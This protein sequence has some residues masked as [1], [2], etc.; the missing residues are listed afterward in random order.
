MRG[1]RIGRLP[2]FEN[3]EGIG[4]VHDRV[5]LV[6][7]APLLC[8][9]VRR[10]LA[11]ERD[12]LIPSTGLHADAD[13]DA[14]GV[15]HLPSILGRAVGQTDAMTPNEIITLVALGAFAFLLLTVWGTGRRRRR[16]A[17]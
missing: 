6:L 4:V 11:E 3:D 14:Y 7:D 17:E 12:L 10:D 5:Q 16:R 2:P 13:D 15:R 1:E 8:A 9:N